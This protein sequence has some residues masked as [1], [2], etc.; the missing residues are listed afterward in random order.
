MHK[1]NSKIFIRRNESGI[2]SIHCAFSDCDGRSCVWMGQNNKFSINA[3]EVRRGVE[4]DP[5]SEA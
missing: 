3:I 2:P 4:L 1:I 5:D